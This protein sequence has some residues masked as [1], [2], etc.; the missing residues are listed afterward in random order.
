MSLTDE[1][2]Y[3]KPSL[4]ILPDI[5]ILEI[6]KCLVD[7]DDLL[8][9]SQIG[10]RFPK[11][12]GGCT[13]LWTRIIRA[14]PISAY[15]QMVRIADKLKQELPD[16]CQAKLIYLVARKTKLNMRSGG[17]RKV[18]EFSY[19]DWRGDENLARHII[20]NDLFGSIVITESTGDQALLNFD[21]WS[22]RDLRD[23]S[24]SVEFDGQDAK[25]ETVEV[26][27]R[28][29]VVD[30]GGRQSRNPQYVSI[31][32]LIVEC[33]THLRSVCS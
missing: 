18:C 28:T 23:L 4:L 5:A 30:V 26:F 10:S 33:H 1:T 8:A 20:S 2:R 27:D 21:F 31:F 25:V 29:V 3:P 16:A 7:Q 15:P 17:V 12:I 13:S 19:P 22:T 11:L 24:S 9:F 32:G 6:S 14:D